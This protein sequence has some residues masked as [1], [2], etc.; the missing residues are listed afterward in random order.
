MVSRSASAFGSELE[1]EV[2]P[3]VA[4]PHRY[5]GHEVGIVPKSWDATSVRVLFCYPDLYEVGMS[6]TGT[7][8]L[9]HVVNR[10]PAWLMERAYAPWPDLEQ[11]MRERGIPLFSL[12]SR[13]PAADFDVIAFTLQSE[14][15]YT[16][17]LTM[18]DLAGLPLRATERRPG[19]PLVIGGGPAASNP[20]PIAA[21][22]DAFVLGDG[23]DALPEILSLIGA[24]KTAESPTP[25]TPHP[26]P[27]G[28][29]ASP[30]TELLWRLATEVAGVY[31]PAF[32]D[33]PPEGGTARPNDPRL[34]WPVVA[35]TVPV[36]RDED[37]P[38]RPLVPLA[39]VTHER[40]PIE[41]QRG[42]VRGCRFCQAGYLYRPVRERSAQA[43][44]AIAA[45]GLSHGGQEE[46]SLLSLSTADHSAIDAL[47]GEVSRLAAER[48]A[49]VALP[50][51]RA[52]AFSVALV[53]AASRVRRTG[54]TFAPEAGSE[55]LRR[56]INKG[57]E[58]S[59]ILAAVERALASGWRSVKLY[60][61]IGHPTETQADLEE[62]ARLVGRIRQLVRRSGARGVALSIS[63][64][65]PK[66]H[67][68]FQFERQDSLEETRAKLRWIK[69]HVSGP[70]VEVKYHDLDAIT[71]EGMLSRGGREGA[72]LIEGAWRRGA[73]LDGWTEQLKL[74][75]WMASLAA[76]GETTA[77]RF[78]ERREDEPLPWEV[79]TYGIA[80][81]YFVRERRKAYA[82][83]QT[84]ECKLGRCSAC[85][86][87]DFEG[88]QNRLA[89]ESVAGGGW[90][91]VGEAQPTHTP[92]P[93]TQHRVIR[94][95]YAKQA[96]LRFLTHLDVMREI[97]RALRRAEV[98]VAMS[99][100]FA[101]RPRLGAGPALATGW[102]SDAEWVDV[103]VAGAGDWDEDRL[104]ATLATLN[105]RVAPGLFFVAAGVLPARTRSLG[106]SLAR[107]RLR[108][109]FP[110]PSFASAFAER[111]AGCRRFLARDAVPWQRDGGPRG[112][113]HTIDLRPFVHE[114]AALDGR[115]VVLDLW[116]PPDGSARPTEILEAACGVPRHLAPL[117]IIHRMDTRLAGGGS[118]LDGCLVSVGEHTVE[119]GNSDQ[120]EPA[121]DPRGDSGGRHPC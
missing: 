13:R 48:G 80:R 109:T 104:A 49:A 26:T 7:Q 78:R 113:V 68:P 3:L 8:I 35:R 33:A 36:L 1:R 89:A 59:D 57:L 94:L 37:H 43:C 119:T 93:I 38:R 21:F 2:L 120:W 92:P 17:V 72:D 105:R 110:A 46:I 101:P 50:S 117:I 85:G 64:F 42:C 112:T 61:M 97:T 74:D 99:E 19:D 15:T 100:G 9:Y 44:A 5:V 58:E 96:P 70:G 81:D 118:P 56:V 28:R 23:E 47:V 95:R 11:A 39:T 66:P 20:E 60:L 79:V 40:L 25:N 14:L 27:A 52:D 107:S 69:T 115:S 86:A 84:E 75:A 6:H 16:N 55:R 63:P 91:V 24:A 102:T 12:E 65:V 45:E 54:F 83:H 18:L 30:R 34:P 121:G 106:A 114:L 98:P 82:E 41:V 108:A 4:K 29:A 73:R 10:R 32:Y 62:L 111:D 116:T 51:L 76:L 87:C 90:Q 71:I 103:V 88:L 31:V 53:E 67:T 22:F 77:S